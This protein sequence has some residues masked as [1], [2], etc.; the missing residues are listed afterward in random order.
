MAFGAIELFLLISGLILIGDGLTR[1]P[2]VGDDLKKAAD[3]LSKF[4]IFIGIVNIALAVL[5]IF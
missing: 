1:I 3:W 5:A 4:G 2:K